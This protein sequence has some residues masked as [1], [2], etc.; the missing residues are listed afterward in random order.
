MLPIKKKKKK[1]KI[2]KLAKHHKSFFVHSNFKDENYIEKNMC[3][4]LFLAI[5]FL[6]FKPTREVKILK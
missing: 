2:L 6:H 1:I 5:H 4:I 3:Q